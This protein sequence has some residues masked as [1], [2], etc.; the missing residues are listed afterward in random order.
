MIKEISIDELGSLANPVLVDVRSEGEYAE[1]T[2]GGAVNLPIFNNAERARIGTIY[3]QESPNAARKLGLQLVSPK[4]PGIV[5]KAIKLGQQ[6]PLVFFCWRGGMRSKAV[7]TVLDLMGIPVY[8]LQGG[9][10][11]YRRRVVEFFQKALPFHV[12]VLRGNTG[13]GKTEL[14]AKLRQKGYPAIDLEKFANNRGSVFGAV[15]LG[16][17]PSQKAFESMLYEEIRTVSIFP[18]LVVECE[19]KRIGRVTLPDSFYQAMQKGTQVLIYDTVE[20]RV[21][22]LVQEYTDFPDAAGQIAQALDRLVKTLGRSKVEEY[23][24]LLENR[25]FAD[26]TERLLCEYYDPL[27]RYP[28][29][30][31][32]EYDLCLS[33]EN[34]QETLRGLENYLDE[35]V[36]T[37]WGGS[38]LS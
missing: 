24:S 27:Y 3:T 37:K 15:G 35:R 9:Y 22:R 26:F 31:S 34:P 13:T 25:C 1:D 18:Y 36:V 30:P 21:R 12:V 29:L 32:A 7:A 20:N 38:P 33:H 6:G 10:K 4:L 11:A 8:R 23:R 2:I 28:N 14:L 17:P 19:S 16:N 5:E